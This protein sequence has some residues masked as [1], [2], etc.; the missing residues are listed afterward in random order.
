MPQVQEH[1]A[2]CSHRGHGSPPA[3][4]NLVHTSTIVVFLCL[5][6]VA[7]LFILFFLPEKIEKLVALCGLSIAFAFFA[8]ICLACSPESVVLYTV[9]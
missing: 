4:S 7:P 6:V 5:F 2:K 8:H 3:T 1:S 9:G